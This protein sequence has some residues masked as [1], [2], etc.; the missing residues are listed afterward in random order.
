MRA[1]ARGTFREAVLSCRQPFHLSSIDRFNQGIA[2]GKVTIQ[3][4]TYGASLP[5][6]VV[7]AGIRAKS[8]KR[9]LGPF[10]NP[11]TVAQS[12]CA[13]FSARLAGRGL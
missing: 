5:G 7:E 11:L 2:G 8:G 13:R 9:V 4:S 1:R 10:K 12:V 3:S 6:D